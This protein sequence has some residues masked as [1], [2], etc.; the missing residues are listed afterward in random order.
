MTKYKCIK[1]HIYRAAC[2]RGPHTLINKKKYL[3]FNQKDGN[4]KQNNLHCAHFWE[5]FYKLFV[6]K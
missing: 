3:T 6:T 2:R 1:C 5:V 4:I